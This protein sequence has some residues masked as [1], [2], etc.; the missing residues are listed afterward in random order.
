MAKII[1][2]S[3]ALIIAIH[4]M[5]L[6]KGS[7]APLNSKNIADKSGFSKNHV[8]KILQQLARN[9]YLHATRGP[10]GGYVIKGNP[11]EMNLLEIYRLFEGEISYDYCKQD[12]INCPFKKCI[13]DGITRKMTNEF[14]TY[15]LHKKVSEL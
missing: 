4:S 2:I 9:N 5:G 8:S 14:E 7:S 1:N 15:L 10:K 13:F 12:C 3:D 6:I 11:E